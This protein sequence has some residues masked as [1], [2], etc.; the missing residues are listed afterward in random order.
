M[1]KFFTFIIVILFV[2][3]VQLGLAQN[4]GDGL[5]GNYY[6]N[7]KTDSIGTIIFEGLT[8][9]FSRIDTMINF[10]DGS[11]YF[12]WQP[13]SGWGNHYSVNWSGFIY[14][15]EPG[16]Y[17]FGTIS[18]DGSQVFI[19]SA[20]IVDN[21]ELQWYDWE[22]NISEGDPGDT[23]ATSF[24]QLFL[25]SGFHSITVTFYEDANY[26]GIELW[27]LK[28]GI[29]SSDIPYY[30]TTF[31]GAAPTF[32]PN[33]NW[34]LVPKSVLYSKI[35]TSL[36]DQEAFINNMPEQAE[37]LQ[38][39]PNPFNP[40]TVISYTI[41]SDKPSPVKVDLS[42]YNLLGQK[43]TTLVSQFQPAGE[44]RLT[45]DASDYPAGI[46]FCRLTTNNGYEQTRKLM[47]VK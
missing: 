3:S 18:D 46:Y 28:P 17:G 22:D 39:Y 7:Y 47:L 40:S 37:L 13:V 23:L 35:T 38:N 45:W 25:E 8:E 30:G 41:N 12:Q 36:N 5:T 34:E 15:E 31:H 43:V 26:D 27:W 11:R 4:G 1:N 20:L 29:D 6:E 24:P 10:W 44:Y 19:D 42:I 16:E 9:S 21:H 33:T 32:N 14:I 2:A